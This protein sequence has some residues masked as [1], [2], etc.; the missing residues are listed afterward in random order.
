M[1]NPFFYD[2]T[3]DPDPSLDP[4]QSQYKC[5]FSGSGSLAPYSI[6]GTKLCAYEP[7]V[8][9]SGGKST[10]SWKKKKKKW[11]SWK[12]LNCDW[13]TLVVKYED[14]W[15]SCWK[16]PDIVILPATTIEM[17]VDTNININQLDSSY[18]LTTTP[19]SSTVTLTNDSIIIADYN[20]QHDVTDTTTGTIYPDVPSMTINIKTNGVSEPPLYIPQKEFVSDANGNY[21][22]KTSILPDSKTTKVDDGYTYETHII[23][24]MYI[25]KNNTTSWIYYKV[26]LTLY[27]FDPYGTKLDTITSVFNLNLKSI[28][29]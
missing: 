16:S 8:S 10:C 15:G 28:T 22:T 17:T 9:W 2:I 3:K 19:P 4:T 14:D 7:N 24:D 18:I 23:M 13:K 25:D 12:T 11:G 29:K 20:N 27:I 26:D 1:S 6:E 21:P 5:S